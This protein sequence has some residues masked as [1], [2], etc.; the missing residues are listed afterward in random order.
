MDHLTGSDFKNYHFTFACNNFYPIA[1]FFPYSMLTGR[2]M[3]TNFWPQN[4]WKFYLAKK[5][6]KGTKE[7]DMCETD[8]DLFY[9]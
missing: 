7:G 6:T 1:S 8:A 4:M 5:K 3:N 2:V 9:P